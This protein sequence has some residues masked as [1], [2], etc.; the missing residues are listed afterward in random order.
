MEK[1]VYVD[2]SARHVHLPEDVYKTL[3]GQDAEMTP[4]K[5]LL[6]GGGFVDANRVILEGPKGKMERVAILGPYRPTQIELSKT[7]ARKLG[8]DA[9]IRLSGDT[10][11]SAPIKIIG[12]A[13]EYDATEGAI[14][15]KRHIHLSPATCEELGIAKDDVLQVRVESDDRTLIFDDVIARP[16]PA[17]MD[18]MHIDTDEGNAAGLNGPVDGYMITK[19]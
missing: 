12:T 3:F 13:G 19:K 11:G 18:L 17:D 1:K 5:E 16:A 9:P 10:K 6:G 7:D 14:V 4:V 8:V 2:I 15:A